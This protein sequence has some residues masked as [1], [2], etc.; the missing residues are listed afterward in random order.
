MVSTLFH[1]MNSCDQNVIIQDLGLFWTLC[2]NPEFLN[3][4]TL[5]LFIFYTDVFVLHCMF[6]IHNC[7]SVVV[8]VCICSSVVLG[9]AF[10]CVVVTAGSMYLVRSSRCVVIQQNV[11][12]CV[13]V[14]PT[15]CHFAGPLLYNCNISVLICQYCRAP[16]R[17][18]THAYVKLP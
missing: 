16:M 15:S 8:E 13:F 17:H 10:F 6:C 5:L 14:N 1:P 2:V 11:Y 3:P 9:I 7:I 18:V 4:F 12:I